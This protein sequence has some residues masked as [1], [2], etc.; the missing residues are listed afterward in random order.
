[1]NLCSTR[2]CSVAQHVRTPPNEGWHTAPSTFLVSL[3]HFPLSSHLFSPVPL[4]SCCSCR[5]AS[6]PHTPINTNSY[7]EEVMCTL[8]HNILRISPITPG[9]GADTIVDLA[10]YRLYPS[11]SK[12]DRFKLIEEGAAAANGKQVVVALQGASAKAA[13]L[14]VRAITVSQEVVSPPRQNRPLLFRRSM[15]RRH[16]LM[17]GGPGD[18]LRTSPD[19]WCPLHVLSPDICHP[20]QVQRVTELLEDQHEKAVNQLK[21]QLQD[22]ESERARLSASVERAKAQ[23]QQ[24]G[25]AGGEETDTL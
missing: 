23:L 10:S 19:I 3:F 25:E 2:P 14:W 8:Q 17:C 13:Q 11:D 7:R 22:R 6:E 1:M 16:R 4:P 24:V 20:L 12:H 18:S 5:P 15:P 21:A 9:H